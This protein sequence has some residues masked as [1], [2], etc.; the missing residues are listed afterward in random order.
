MVAGCTLALGKRF[1]NMAKQLDLSSAD[2][3]DF[4]DVVRV[5]HA[6]IADG[7]TAYFVPIVTLVAILTWLWMSLCLSAKYRYMADESGQSAYSP[8]LAVMQ[9]PISDA[10]SYTGMDATSHQ[11]ECRISKPEAPACM[12]MSFAEPEGTSKQPL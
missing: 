2:L 11:D 6:Q 8:P 9:K 4:G 1:P 12:C 7:L 10:T 3:L 5:P